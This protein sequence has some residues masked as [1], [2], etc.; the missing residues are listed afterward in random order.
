MKKYRANGKLLLSGEYFVLDGAVSLGLPTK[1]GQKMTIEHKQTMNNM[2][3]LHWQSYTIDN[4]CWFEG[5]FST[6]GLEIIDSTNIEVAELLQKILRFAI[7]KKVQFIE[8]NKDYW[9]KTYLEFPRVFGLGSSSTLICLIAKWAN[10]DPFELLFNSMKGSGYDIACGMSDS[11]V[12]YQLI[13]QYPISKPVIFQPPFQSHIYFVHL[14]QKQN[15]R[16]GIARYRKKANNQDISLER[17]SKL[18]NALFTVTNLQDFNKYIEEHEAI[19][20]KT[21]E[22]PRAKDVLFK[23]YSLGEIKSLG[24]WGGDF[25]MATSR[26]D[27]KTTRKY[28]QEKGFGTIFRWNELILS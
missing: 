19:V 26:L 9:V 11:P 18:T 17:I 15:S 3:M 1:L 28:F 25:I 20:S 24:A 14:N 22:L 7:T 5:R 16:E 27:D 10:I 6:K 2:N 23:D 4:E 8:N 12:L 21:I 13:D